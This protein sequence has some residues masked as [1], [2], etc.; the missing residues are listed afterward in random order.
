MALDFKATNKNIEVAKELTDIINDLGGSI[1]LAKDAVMDS[2]HFD[3]QI[4]KEH[5]VEFSKFRHNSITSQQSIRI[6]L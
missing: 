2:R 5:K 3:P 4:S 6:K 1:Y